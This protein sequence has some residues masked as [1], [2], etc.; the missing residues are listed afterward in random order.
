M[1]QARRSRNQAHGEIAHRSRRVSVGRAQPALRSELNGSRAYGPHAT[2]R[3]HA[4]SG[5]IV[6]SRRRAMEI[7][8]PIDETDQDDRPVTQP[9]DATREGRSSS[10]TPSRARAPLRPRRVPA[11]RTAR[12]RSHDGA[13]HGSMRESMSILRLPPTV[14][15]D[16]G[17]AFPS[18]LR[19]FVASSLPGLDFPHRQHDAARSVELSTSSIGSSPMLAGIDGQDHA[20][21]RTPPCD[22]ACD[23]PDA[24]AAR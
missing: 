20:R 17:Q 12:S 1:T 18:S 7:T 21:P 3:W 10:P 22:V 4:F 9:I 8:A 24:R 5:G 6:R 11:G 2:T 19:R 15:E 16:C 13:R 23:A 14:H